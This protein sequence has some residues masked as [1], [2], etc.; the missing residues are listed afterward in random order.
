MIVQKFHTVLALAFVMLVVPCTLSAV[1]QKLDG[2]LAPAVIVSARDATETQVLAAYEIQRYIYLRTGKI[3]PVKSRLPSTGDAITI[4][5]DPT[6]RQQEY[7]LKT[8]VQIDRKLLTITG[9]SDVASLWGAYHFAEKLGVRFFLH[10][11][12]I[13][14]QRLASFTIPVLGEIHQPLFELRGLNPWGS[15]P[16]GLD[17]WN[18]DDWKA[19]IGQMAKLRLNFIGMHCYPEGH[20]YAEPTV[21]IG[22]Q[23]DIDD[24]G[25][26]TESY[27]AVYYNTLYKPWWGNITTRKTSE[28]RLGSAMLFDRDSWGPEV[29]RGLTPYP[30]KPEA[31]NELFNRTGKM[32]SEAF[33]FARQV[34]IK[35]CLGTEA[36]L[37]IPEILQEKLKA[38]GKDPADPIVVREVY[39]GIFRRIMKSHPLDY[40]WI[41]TAESWTWEGNSPQQLKA[42]ID[43]I[44]I[45]RE[46]L[47]NVGNPFKMATA[48]WVLGPASNRFALDETLPK[49]IDL[50][51]ISRQLGHSPVD[52]AFGRINP[53]RGR[54]AIPWMEDDHALTSPQL[55]VGRTRKDAADALAYGS[56]GLMGLQWRTRILGPNIAALAQAGWDQTSWNPQPGK[57]PTPL[58]HTPQPMGASD[59]LG[60]KM[61]AYPD[62][63]ITGTDDDELYRTCRY[64]LSE[65][66]LNIPNGSYKVI[67]K[68]CEPHFSVAGQR[69]CTVLLQGKTVVKKL[70][71]FHKVGQ[72]AALDYIFDE[73]KVQDGK[74]IVKLKYIQSLPCISAIAVEGKNFSKKINLGG[75]VYKD[76]AADQKT[77]STAISFAG[78]PRPQLSSTDFY[79]D[80]ASIFGNEVNKQISGIFTRIDGRVPRAAASGCP[81]NI[82]ADDRLWEM[83]NTEYQ[84]VDDL[85]MLRSKVRGAGNLERF[86][87]WLN[88]FKYL[89]ATA[90]MEFTLGA[91]NRALIV[92]QSQKNPVDKKH[93]AEQNAL[94]A[95]RKLVEAYQ[96]AFG[97]LLASINT[98][99][100]LATIIFWEHKYRPYAIEGTGKQLTE[101]LGTQL[102]RDT[103][104]T[105]TYTGAP[106]LIIPTRRSLI[107]QGESMTLQI[108]IMDQHRP[109]SAT[110]YWRPMGKGE[111]CEIELKHVARAVYTV[112]LPPTAFTIEYYIQVETSGGLPLIWPATAPDINYT[113]VVVGKQ[114]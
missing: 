33:T 93:A 80:W 73:V 61:A 90:K 24:Q 79:D 53:E 72:F 68:F 20:P 88:T 101:L 37:T 8:Y 23:E 97:Y 104:L 66:T 51:A 60:G 39:E 12:V 58:M 31:C 92:A 14:D 46:A 74:L 105:D 106:R 85:A 75:T 11:D 111:Y 96:E 84:F 98:P 94:P 15:H 48:G 50:S 57:L 3:L 18:S 43:D 108:I 2:V 77:T 38:K 13:P 102:P 110:L 29:I 17:L 91:F 65:L 109:K 30:I 69:V 70:D 34:G 71:I 47:K 67:L 26:V 4:A 82:R 112:T 7:R 27:P 99:G 40:Y 21:W 45:A 78:P 59:F 16:F 86:D 52:P 55:W 63:P 76:Y 114:P 49:D 32:F 1:P 113:L 56:S 81:A 107:R 42:V 5:I 41:W 89:R 87:Y 35:T 44:K 64:D 103:Q 25:L 9:G 10:G 100:C 28:Y 19:H 6:L 36:P 54:W 62:K 95:Y 22:L 83:V